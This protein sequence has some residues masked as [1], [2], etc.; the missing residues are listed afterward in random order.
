M[1]CIFLLSILLFAGTVR[2]QHLSLKDQKPPPGFENIYTQKLASDS[3]GTSFLIWV[4]KEVKP[5]YHASH[6]EVLYVLEGKGIFTLD[7][8]SFPFRAG[9]YLLI[10]RKQVHSLQVTSEKPMKILSVQAPEFDG[11]DR[12]FTK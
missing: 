3:L 1:R 12:I 2:G 6:T 4:K 10:P 8:N 9:D 7:S 5:H 11:S